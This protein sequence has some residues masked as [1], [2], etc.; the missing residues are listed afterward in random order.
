M[1]NN[2]SACARDEPLTANESGDVAREMENMRKMLTES[3][4]MTKQMEQMVKLLQNE[5]TAVEEIACEED[6]DAWL[7]S[8]D[9][10]AAQ[11][12]DINHD[13]T[14]EEKVEEPEQTV[15]SEEKRVPLS[16]ERRRNSVPTVLMTQDQ[17]ST[18]LRTESTLDFKELV[19]G[20]KRTKQFELASAESTLGQ[21]TEGVGQK[22]EGEVQ[23]MAVKKAVKKA[24]SRS[25]ENSVSSVQEERISPASSPPDSPPESPS[26]E[27]PR[28]R[29]GEKKYIVLDQRIAQEFRL[30]LPVTAFK[31]QDKFVVDRPDHFCESP[32]SVSCVKDN[33][34]FPPYVVKRSTAVPGDYIVHGSDGHLHTYPKAAFK[35]RYEKV[36]G[37]QFLYRSRFTVL[38]RPMRKSFRVLRIDGGKASTHNRKLER[39]RTAYT[40]EA[41][42][43][44]LRL[45][46][47]LQIPEDED[48]REDQCLLYRTALIH[49]SE[50]S[51]NKREGK[52]GEYLVQLCD[53]KQQ[54][55]SPRSRMHSIEGK[56]SEVQPRLIQW[57]VGADEMRDNYIPLVYSVLHAS[58]SA[59]CLPDLPGGDQRLRTT[60][61]AGNLTKQNDI[62]VRCY[63]MRRIR[64]ASDATSGG[65]KLSSGSSSP[66]S[67]PRGAQTRFDPVVGITDVDLT[68]GAALPLKFEG[69]FGGMEGGEWA[70]AEL[71]DI[72]DIRARA[73]SMPAKLA[74]KKDSGTEL[75]MDAE[76]E[77]LRLDAH[78][79]ANE[80]REMLCG[81]DQW[82][83]DVFHLERFTHREPLLHLGL[84][85]FQ[86]HGLVNINNTMLH[87][88]VRRGS[89]NDVH[90]GGNSSVKDLSSAKVMDENTFVQFLTVIEKT[91]LR[92][93][94][95]HNNTHGADVM[96]SVHHFLCHT[97][98]GSLLTWLE[99]TAVL[100]AA[101]VHDVGHPGVSNAFQIN[102]RSKHAI[103][104][105]DIS[106]LENFH[107]ATAFKVMQQE[108]CEILASYSREEHAA[109]RRI[110][111]NTILATDL[112][113]H[114]EYMDQC[115]GLFTGATPEKSPG[116]FAGKLQ[117]LFEAD[118]SN[119]MLVLSMTLKC[120]DIGHPARPCEYHLKWSEYCFQEF[121]NQYVQE[122]HRELPISMRVDKSDLGRAQSQIGFIKYLVQPMYG[123][124]GEFFDKK[125]MQLEKLGENLDYWQK[126]QEKAQMERSF[127][128]QRNAEWF[129]KEF[130]QDPELLSI[131]KETADSGADQPKDAAGAKPRTKMRRKSS[132]FSGSL[133]TELMRA[134]YQ[135]TRGA[136]TRTRTTPTTTTAT[137]HIRRTS[138]VQFTGGKEEGEQIK[139]VSNTP[140]R[141]S[142]FVGTYG[143]IAEDGEEL[144]SVGAEPLNAGDR[145]HVIKEGSQ[146]G[147][148]G[149]VDDPDWTGRVKIKMDGAGAIKSY[150]PE[151]LLKLGSSKG[152]NDSTVRLNT[153]D[154]LNSLKTAA[155]V[156]NKPK[157]ARRTK[158]TRRHSLAQPPASR[159]ASL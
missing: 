120:S 66:C 153:V 8:P 98:L 63:S 110:M 49:M 60:G 83:F 116:A 57:V 14:E 41:M 138:A 72:P 48:G 113:K 131:T 130:K 159:A 47:D 123:A 121:A 61:S 4:D 87:E 54:P 9:P 62:N 88:P 31:A 150:L 142:A 35:K 64:S 143:S 114:R 158:A 152:A 15:D 23:L 36:E 146:K 56:E 154:T 144:D 112:A 99:I 38:A 73:A 13:F 55:I 33:Q 65:K 141:S 107:A 100:L 95:Y 129:A 37:K 32:A 30:A 42:K 133:E 78:S 117:Q 75:M 51:R 91:Y 115:K 10:Y 43:T 25:R 79:W 90:Q 17:I 67:S 157:P 92:D 128:M 145:V 140:R 71:G 156:Y 69:A 127:R 80:L 111:V 135:P 26:A 24:V 59:R 147:N 5:D 50:E 103:R 53:S 93:N 1:G 21:K 20:A 124:Y 74:I 104:Y 136:T 148:V 58:N 126:E 70:G 28:T 96:Q 52:P 6:Y 94:P 125:L 137:S 22:T 40:Q 139:T 27:S 11:T 18:E 7:L 155:E 12:T 109:V 45:N 134:T 44:A 68:L 149:T 118:G 84:H 122:K 151:E 97:T 102:S 46:A 106:V 39:S 3:Q 29:S 119:K 34:P 19:K 101:A 85:I 2:L 86:S 132:M 76:A 77:L 105:N 82:D 81:A 16:G 108:R 89:F